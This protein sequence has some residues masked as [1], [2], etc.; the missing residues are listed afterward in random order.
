[1]HTCNSKY[2]KTEKGQHEGSQGKKVCPESM[3]NYVNVSARSSKVK[4][5]KTSIGLGFEWLL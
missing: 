2:K 3:V 5:D 1:M 4:T